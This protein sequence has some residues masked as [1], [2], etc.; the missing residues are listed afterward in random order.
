MLKRSLVTVG[1]SVLTVFTVLVGAASAQNVA[2]GIIAGVVQDPSDA[3]LPGVTV[4][5]ASPALI[6]RVRA[7]ITNERGLYRIIDL[8][9]GTYTVTFTLPGFSTTVREGIVLTAGF[10][11][12][13]NAEMRL[14]AF[15][16]T[17]T[18]SSASPVVDVQNVLQ[19]TAISNEERAALPLPSNSG[20]YVTLIP[21]ATQTNTANQ[22]VGGARS[23][24]TQQFTIHGNA[25]NDYQQLRDGMYYGTMIAAGNYMSAVNPIALQEVTIVT[26]GGILAESESGGVQ[27]DIVPRDG[28]EITSGSFLY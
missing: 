14:G 21:G 12:S 2:S 25:G 10:T 9:T 7:T 23:E 24:L 27:I 19:K 16:E 8:R 1:F 15:K 11:A 13:M 4:E 18:V 20:A 26:G 22:D 6:E 17:I 28:G 3:V 5:V